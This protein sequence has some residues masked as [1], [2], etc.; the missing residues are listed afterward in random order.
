MV[1][2]KRENYYIFSTLT[3]YSLH[4]FLY[5]L[6]ID[7]RCIV[8]A[9]LGRPV[10]RDTHIQFQPALTCKP[11]R[12]LKRF[13]NGLKWQHVPDFFH[14]Q[15]TPNPFIQPQRKYFHVRHANATASFV[16]SFY[17]QNELKKSKIA[18][19][20]HVLSFL[21]ELTIFIIFHA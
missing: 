9:N 4:S 2:P 13:F 20:L 5:Q 1:E 11:Q 17:L 12:V 21:T 3:M 6:F 8:L 15:W 10:Q 18:D 16:R 19:N 7:D 14:V